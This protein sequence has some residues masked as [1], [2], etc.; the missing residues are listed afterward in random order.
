MKLL[1]ILGGLLAAIVAIVVIGGVILPKDYR[2]E[3]SVL[4]SA[5]ADLAYA[6]V[7]NLERWNDWSPWKKMDP[8]M[9]VTYG[10]KKEGV[11]AS[12]AW[13]GEAA[14]KG[15][16]T[17][18]TAEP[19]KSLTTFVD[20]GARGQSDGYWRFEPSG[21]E[22]RVTWGFSGTNKGIFG[23]WFSMMMDDMV[24]AQFLEGLQGIKLLAEK[25]AAEAEELAAKQAEEA[26]AAAAA[27]EA[28]AGSEGADAAAEG[29]AVEGEAKPDEAKTQ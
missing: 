24:G 9:K 10:D 28:A 14:G 1:K 20:F 8:S 17:I 21:E 4:V 23:G 16:L 11:G 13:D 6:Q 29:A 25:D 27:A 12:Y 26:A 15:E 7:S 18:K 3:R 5:P 22:T 19:G 2:V